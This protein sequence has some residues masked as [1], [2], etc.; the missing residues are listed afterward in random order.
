MCSGVER[1]KKKKVKN[2]DDNYYISK[3]THHLKAII[4]KL[5]RNWETKR[6]TKVAI[7]I[8]THKKINWNAKKKGEN[9]GKGREKEKY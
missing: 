9:F 4:Y 6:L 1:K 3:R 8:M 7:I 5:N 2:D